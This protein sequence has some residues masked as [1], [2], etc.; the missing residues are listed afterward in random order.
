MCSLS[1]KLCWYGWVGILCKQTFRKKCISLRK[2]GI[3]KR[4]YW[5]GSCQYSQ[6]ERYAKEDPE[7]EFTFSQ[8]GWFQGWGNYLGETEC[9]SASLAS[10]A[11]HSLSGKHS[12]RSQLLLSLCPRLGTF[13]WPLMTLHFVFL[14]QHAW[15]SFSFSFPFHATLQGWH[16]WLR[17]LLREDEALSCMGGSWE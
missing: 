13:A 10:E 11:L 14:V 5:W 6:K 1:S 17:F 7:P 8:K 12:R 4:I 2:Q 9:L 16:D 15:S 3:W